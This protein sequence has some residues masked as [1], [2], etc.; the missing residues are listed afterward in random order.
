MLNPILFSLYWLLAVLVAAQSR[1]EGGIAVSQEEKEETVLSTPVLHSS[2][3]PA[4]TLPVVQAIFTSFWHHWGQT[5]TLVSLASNC[6]SSSVYSIFL[7]D[8]VK[9]WNSWESSKASFTALLRQPWYKKSCKKGLP[10]WGGSGSCLWPGKQRMI[11]P[12]TVTFWLVRG[13]M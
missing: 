8:P 2:C 10:W 12:Q 13:R 3:S 1:K 11:L 5:G 4:E 6:W 7:I 9:S